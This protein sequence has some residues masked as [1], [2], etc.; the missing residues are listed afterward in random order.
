MAELIIGSR[1]GHFPIEDPSKVPP[2][3]FRVVVHASPVGSE[4]S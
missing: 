1:R 2:L 4:A 3:R